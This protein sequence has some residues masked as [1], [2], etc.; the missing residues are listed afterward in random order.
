MKLMLDSRN[1]DVG[2][3]MGAHNQIQIEDLS[4]FVI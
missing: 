2:M 3:I 4:A 1:I